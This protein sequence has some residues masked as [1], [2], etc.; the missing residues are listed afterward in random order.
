MPTTPVQL[1]TQ[2]KLRY[3]DKNENSNLAAVSPLNYEKTI[4]KRFNFD[5]NFK[6]ENDDQELEEP[7]ENFGN[8]TEKHNENIPEANIY[9]KTQN[10]KHKQHFARIV[11]NEL[12]C[13]RK[14]GDKEPRVMHSLIGTFIKELP[15]ET[16]SEQK[17]YFPIKIM[18]PPNKSRIL[19]FRNKETQAIWLKE[20]T[21]K[22]GFTNMQDYYKLEKDLGK[23]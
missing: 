18:I 21:K 17:E 3:S 23:G 9:L 14:Q 19:H 2:N 4:S 5:E 15:I 12:F 13:Y 16:D 7:I 20:L 11:G 1:K 10:N 8:E 22:V 6:I